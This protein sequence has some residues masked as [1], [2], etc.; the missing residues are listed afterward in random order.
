MK[1]NLRSSFAG[2][3]P[4]AKSKTVTSRLIAAEGKVLLDN[5]GIHAE[6]KVKEAK[7]R[8]SLEMEP[9]ITVSGGTGSEK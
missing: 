6:L 4:S 9:D 8:F 3:K 5:N 1:K 7:N 2:S